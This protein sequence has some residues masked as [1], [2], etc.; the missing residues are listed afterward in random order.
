M[1]FNDSMPAT[2]FHVVD[3]RHRGWLPNGGEHVA[4]IALTHLGQV[5]CCALAMA[6]PNGVHD[7]AALRR[8]QPG[9]ED[10]V[11]DTS[12]EA[13]CQRGEHDAPD[14]MTHE[15]QR[16]GSGVRKVACYRARRIADCDR[17]DVG[18]PIPAARKV[19]R[20]RRVVE[21]LLYLLPDEGCV[22]RSVHEDERGAGWV[23]GHCVQLLR[24]GNGAASR[25][26]PSRSAGRL[27]S[28]IAAT[29]GVTS[30]AERMPPSPTS[31]PSPDK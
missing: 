23:V 6:G 27:T 8:G 4:L 29:V 10:E 5:L 24:C 1:K 22:T 15:H 2:D 14:R 28:S 12:C 25:L 17:G 20:H 9:H 16:A 3:R 7:C 19:N 31:T 26:V 13:G 18:R 30:K 11:L 21:M